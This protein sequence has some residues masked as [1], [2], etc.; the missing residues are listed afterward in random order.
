MSKEI[1]R[2]LGHTE[3]CDLIKKEYPRESVVI[4]NEHNR[5]IQRDADYIILQKTVREISQ[6]YDEYIKLFNEEL[7]EIFGLAYVHVWRSTRTEAGRKCRDKIQVL[8]S[9]YLEGK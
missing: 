4:S 1:M 9:E 8:K 3:T 5:Q 6:A 7:S 2:V